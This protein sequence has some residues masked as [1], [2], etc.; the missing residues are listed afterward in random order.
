MP[1][2]LPIHLLCPPA[3]PGPVSWIGVGGALGRPVAVAAPR[4]PRRRREGATTRTTPPAAAVRQ[5]RAASHH[6]AAPGR[7]GPPPLKPPPAHPHPPDT[8]GSQFFL[9]TVETPWLDGRHV[10]FGEVVEGM[11]IVHKI[12]K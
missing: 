5:R 4:R 3:A 6:R 2:P 8:N 10:V 11:D 12:E 7:Q 1:P 9:C